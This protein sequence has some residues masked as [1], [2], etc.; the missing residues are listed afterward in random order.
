MYR[1]DERFARC[2]AKAKAMART[3]IGVVF[4]GYTNTLVMLL[5][6]VRLQSLTVQPLAGI[7]V[8]NEQFGCTYIAFHNK[9]ISGFQALRRV[10]APMAGLEPG[11]EGS[12]QISGQIRG[13]AIDAPVQIK[14][15]NKP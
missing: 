12:L 4:S 9:V 6:G 7:F 5:A 15:D 1:R 10:R 11:T 8:G 3:I 2:S 14:A 13:L